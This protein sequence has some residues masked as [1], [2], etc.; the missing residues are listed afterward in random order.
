MTRR[1]RLLSWSW[2]RSGCWLWYAS[3]MI[4]HGYWIFCW[5]VCCIRIVPECPFS[6]SFIIWLIVLCQV[7][8]Y[9]QQCILMENVAI[10]CQIMSLRYVPWKHTERRFRI[11]HSQFPWTKSYGKEKRGILEMSVKLPITSCHNS[12]FYSLNKHT[13]WVKNTRKKIIFSF[14]VLTESYSF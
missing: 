9:C 6:I 1:L 13:C 5:L 10:W 8:A 2:Y 3:I 7:H 4:C 11:Y 14:N 12:F